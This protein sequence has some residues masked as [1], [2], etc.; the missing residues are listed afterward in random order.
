MIA[1]ELTADG[2][3]IAVTLM[4]LVGLLALVALFYRRTGRVET[5]LG[6]LEVGV[7]Q[8]NKQVNHVTDPEREPKLRDLVTATHGMVNAVRIEQA[9]QS[10]HLTETRQLIEH[11]LA[12]HQAEADRRTEGE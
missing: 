3:G 2:G 10:R 12:A 7:E 9:A 4:G 5:K 8:I 1:L 11:H 6:S